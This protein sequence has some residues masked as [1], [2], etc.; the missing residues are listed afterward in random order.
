MHSICY[1]YPSSDLANAFGK[2]GYMVTHGETLTRFDTY[3]E[4]LAFAQ[5]LGTEPDRWSIDHPKNVSLRE[6]AG[7]ASRHHARMFA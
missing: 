4:A 3:P 1:A 2:H 7:R 6:E 5:S